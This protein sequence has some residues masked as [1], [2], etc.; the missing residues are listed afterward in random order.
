MNE[1]KWN[2][3][4]FPVPTDQC[5]VRSVLSYSCPHFTYDNEN[6]RKM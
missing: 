4:S 5:P 2:E 6:V 1:I 3:F